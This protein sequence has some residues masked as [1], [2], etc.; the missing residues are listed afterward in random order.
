[1][2]RKLPSP[3]LGFIN[4][5]VFCINTIF[6]CALLYPFALLKVL[7]PS[8]PAK[9]LVAKILI[10]IANAWVSVNS[11]TFRIS[12]ASEILVFGLDSLESTKSYMIISNHRSWSDIFVLQHIFRNRIPFL[13]F[14]LKQELI[15]VPVLGLAW[16]ALDFPFMKRYS[17]AFLKKHP[18]LRGKDM[19][20]TVKYCEK[21]K[22]SPV[23]VINFLEGTRFTPEKHKKQDSPYT[24]LLVPKAGGVALVFASMG[25]Y[26]SSI[27]DVS[28]V[29]PENEPPVSFWE[30]LSGKI[31]SVHV[32]V[33][34][35]PVP[36]DVVGRNYLED[37][38]YREKIQAWV[39][40]LWQEKDVQIQDMLSG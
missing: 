19:E 8:A 25:N 13:K 30:L 11:F 29:Y 28:I 18:E 36:E 2:K 27:L 34:K 24:H 37:A 38:E 22:R 15:W 21:Y 40:M 32:R 20:T 14:F 5:F 9:R 33:T 31:G 10:G 7:I 6:W 17:R 4:A 23:S 26:L 1:M 16:W 35:R 12:R 3:L 39:N